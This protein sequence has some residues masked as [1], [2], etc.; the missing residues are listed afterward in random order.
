MNILNTEDLIW[1]CIY[2]RFAFQ[3]LSVQSNCYIFIIQVSSHLSKILK[4]N[5]VWVE[6]FLERK[7]NC[8]FCKYITIPFIGRYRD[9]QTFLQNSQPL[10][11]WGQESQGQICRRQEE[12]YCSICSFCWKFTTIKPCYN[13]GIHN[14]FPKNPLC[15]LEFEINH[16]SLWNAHE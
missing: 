9:L 14:P 4:N 6:R 11:F 12:R 8:I 15:E 16:P 10:L 2:R 7:T 13:L 3:S 5:W 1:V